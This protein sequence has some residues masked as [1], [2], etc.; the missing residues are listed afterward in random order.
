MLTDRNYMT[1]GL[2][3]HLLNFWYLYPTRQTQD[4]LLLSK[5]TKPFYFQGN[6][7]RKIKGSCPGLTIFGFTYYLKV[8][9]KSEGGKGSVWFG[10]L[11]DISISQSVQ[12]SLVCVNLILLI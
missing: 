6:R 2:V 4:I 10:R 5:E 1:S 11:S 12:S 9:I 8:I 7:V 3:V